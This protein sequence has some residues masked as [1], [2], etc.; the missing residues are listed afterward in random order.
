M[1][2]MEVAVVL[3]TFNGEKYIKEQLKSL[4]KQTLIPSALIVRDDGSTDN[5]ISILKEWS[6]N[7]GI[8]IQWV[9]ATSRLGPARS[10]L[11]ATAAA[12]NFDY[13]FFCD[14]DDYWL[15]NKIEVAV[16][17]MSRYPSKPVLYASALSVVDENLKYIKKS[18]TP[19]K[20]SFENA[21]YE[22][23]LTGCSMGFNSNFHKLLK[24]EIP[25]YI[26]MHDWWCYILASATGQVIFDKNERILYRQHTSNAVGANGTIISEIGKRWRNFCLP[27]KINERQMQLKN[28]FE[29]YKSEIDVGKRNIIE[30]LICDKGPIKR[31]FIA[32]GIPVVRQSIFNTLSTRLAI[33]LGKF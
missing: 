15:P 32:V 24:I 25:H 6:E 31:F 11:T 33:I 8:R 12:L 28:F 16:E 10:F 18:I 7:S 26:I 30:Y 23:V 13:Y 19:K 29:I 2:K 3:C 27:Q 21:I 22:S 14:Q 1:K 5:T 4:E 20:I 17:L 9:E